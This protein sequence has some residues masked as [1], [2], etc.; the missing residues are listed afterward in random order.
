L[1][2]RNVFDTILVTSNKSIPIN[3]NQS[4]HT[5]P[6]DNTGFG[7]MFMFISPSIGRYCLY[8]NEF[9]TGWQRCN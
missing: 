1:Y 7:F 6:F 4:I 9:W 2:I 3:D 8:C 5:F